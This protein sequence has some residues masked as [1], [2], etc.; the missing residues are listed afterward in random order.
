VGAEGLKKVRDEVE[1]AAAASG[2]DP[3]E[4]TVVAVSKGR[5]DEDVLAAHALGHRDF[6]ENRVAGLED[7]LASHLPN[8]IRWH[9]VGSVQRRKARRLA[10][11]TVLI[12]SID[13]VELAETWARL[14]GGRALLQVNVSGEDQKHGVAPAVAPEVAAAIV[15]IGVD[16]VGLMAI[17][18]RPERPEAS[19]EAFDLLATVRDEIR[20]RLPAVS[21]LSMGMTDD[22]GV[23]VACGATILRIGRAI[24]EPAP[25]TSR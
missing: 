18:R 5:P 8:D 14:G 22:F 20:T 13:R 10:G 7:R 25:H 4:I 19:R 3:R 17:P 16:L 15:A 6:G 11:R 2:R 24:F 9:F 12:H 21:E 1:A 23:A